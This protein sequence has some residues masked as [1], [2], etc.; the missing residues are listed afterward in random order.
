MFKAEYVFV[1]ILAPLLLGIGIFYFFQREELIPILGLITCLLLISLFLLNITYKKLN[2]YKYKGITG[3]LIFVFFFFLGGFLCAL[4]SQKLKADYFGRKD[5]KHLK[6]WVNDEPEQTND[7]LRF[8]VSMVSGYENNKPIKLSGQLLLAL[9]LDSLQPVKLKYGDELIISAKYLEVEPPYNPAEF[10]FK[11]WL[12]SQNVYEQTFINQNHLLKTN[13]NIG[14]PIIEFALDLREKQIAKY[15]KLIKNDE[16]FAVASTL[17]LG[18]RADLSKETLAAYSK[19]GTIHALSVSGSH[20]AIIFFVL[21]FLL[22]FLDKKRGLKILK[23]VIICGLIWSYALITGL[24][25]SVVRSAIMIT[26]FITA[27]TFAK[28]KNGYNTLAFAA[29]CQLIYNPFLIW[30]VGFQLSYISVFGLIYLQPKIY[31][32]LYVKNKWL[33]KI[34]ELVALSL[35]AQLVTFP[36]CIY[37]F[38]QFPVYFLL[39]NLFIS[40]PLIVIMI[41]GIAVLIPIVDKLSPIFEWIIVTTNNVLKWIAD[42]PYSTFSAIWINLPE[43]I[44]LSLALGLFIYALSKYNK[45]LIFTS[46]IVYIFYQAII[47]FDNYTAI[48][49][50]KI[51]FFTLRKN[52]AAAFMQGSK[53][54]ILTDLSESDKNFH[55]FVKPALEQSQISKIDFI[56]LKKDT[57]LGNFILKN[58]QIIFNDYKILLLD[59]SLNYKKLNMKGKFE[60]IWITGNTKFKLENLPKEIQ[61]QNMI[62]DAKNRD[63]KIEIFKTFAENNKITPHILKKNPAYLVQLTK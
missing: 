19:T 17:I 49:Q 15:R 25:P 10:D 57:L 45:Q 13:K 32:W 54:I 33:N 20:V 8:K 35:A 62:I 61:Y 47:V 30:D 39:G 53:A 37:Y 59:E 40:I 7:I 11:R 16:A 34:W 6:V 29:F 60:S 44:L 14:N 21:D 27:K 42:L 24:S 55:F 56:S 58:K 50:K 52:Y 43:L 38:H 9:K 2:G 18:Y 41:L 46:I 63:Y 23:F 22:L 4:N 28:N 31:K 48:T 36:L 5:Y 1:R 26:I 12:A 3:M 51:I